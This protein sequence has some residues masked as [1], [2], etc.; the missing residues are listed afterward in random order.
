MEHR[1][2]KLKHQMRV[3]GFKDI[4]EGSNSRRNDVDGV[5]MCVVSV[6]EAAHRR[7]CPSYSAT[8]ISKQLVRPSLCLLGSTTKSRW[9]S[10]PMDTRTSEEYQ[11]CCRPSWVGTGYLMEGE[12][13]DGGGRGVMDGKGRV[14]SPCRLGPGCQTPPRLYG[15]AGSGHVRVMDV[16][17]HGS[18]VRVGVSAET[19][20]C[21]AQ[22]NV[23]KKQRESSAK[24]LFFPP[25][26]LPLTAHFRRLR[27]NRNGLAAESELIAKRVTKSR[28]G[29]ES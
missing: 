7:S 17:L 23:R 14:G 21:A 25:R 26:L 5:K 4:S 20:V 24:T 2:E 6:Y 1:I 12:W 19:H 11:V 28:K 3:L 18:R 27:P 15:Q 9:S 22:E 29:P 13:A 8:A 16:K 10:T